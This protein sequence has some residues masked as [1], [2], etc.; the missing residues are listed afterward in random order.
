MGRGHLYYSTYEEITGYLMA[1]SVL[2][3]HMDPEKQ[4]SVHSHGNKNLCLLS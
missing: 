1:V 3:N 2:L 4:I